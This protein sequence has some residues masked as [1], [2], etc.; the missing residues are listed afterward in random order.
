MTHRLVSS[1]GVTA[2]VALL[3]ALPAGVAAA[4]C[5]EPLPLGQA[6]DEAQFVFVG[7][8]T[9]LEHEGRLATFAVDDVWKGA[10]GAT[11]VVT[12]GPTPSDL[13]G[14]QAQGQTIVTSVDRNYEMGV[15]YLVLA[16]GTEQGVL[17]DNGCSQTQPY[18]DGLAEFRPAGAA[19][20]PVDGGGSDVLPW[21]L[22]AAAAVVAA[23]GLTA[24]ALWFRRRR[25][26]GTV[27]QPSA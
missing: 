14:A 3:L 19:P 5:A 1:L 4:S 20:P 13:A 9:G 21:A 23:G 2:A 17:L 10:V 16:H 11:A 26:T 18:T 15:R 22:G 6:I 12:G 24:A 25:P 7:T 8:V 27:A